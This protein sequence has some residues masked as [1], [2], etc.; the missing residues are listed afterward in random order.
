MFVFKCTY[1]RE[2][3]RKSEDRPVVKTEVEMC[4]GLSFTRF[5][6]SFMS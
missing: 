1:I 3:E 5:C 4:F 2:K 6:L